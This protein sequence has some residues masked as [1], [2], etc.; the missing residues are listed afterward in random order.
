MFKRIFRFD[1]ISKKVAVMASV[2]T[3]VPV[4]AVTFL[5]VSQSQQALNDVATDDLRHVAVSVKGMC[6]TQDEVLKAKL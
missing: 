5:A 6:Q 3:G 2:L 4:I 1:S